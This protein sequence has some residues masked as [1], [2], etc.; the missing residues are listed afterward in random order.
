M[1]LSIKK[2]PHLLA[3]H[4]AAIAAITLF[5]AGACS[6]DGPGSL[7]SVSHSNGGPQLFVV[8]TS[9]IVGDW[10]SRV[11]GSRVEVF[12][13]LPAGADPHSF[14]PGARDVTKVAEADIVFSVGLAL[15]G[16]W[17][18]KMVR[19]AA[20]DESRV[21]AL[22]EVVGPVES[23]PHFWFDP[24][25]AKAAVSHIAAR[26][27]G[28]DPDGA[29]AYDSNSREYSKE[30]DELHDWIG[31]QITSIPPERRLLVTSHDSF[32]YLA[33]R[34]GFK[35]IGTVAPGV[36]TEVEPS[37]VEMVRL[38]ED[39]RRQGVKAIFTEINGVDRLARA[40][41]EETGA[42]LVN[43]LYTGSLGDGSG[44]A[45]TYIRMMRT[46]VREIVGALRQ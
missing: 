11:G 27:S 40:I 2:I 3:R 23:D 32:G 39:V 43:G 24:L 13:L 25:R 4:A 37:A 45:G 22:G 20:A 12:S 41:A 28:L 10:V 34:Y 35:V 42:Q 19:N 17:L 21:V 6:N 30:L 29:E 38:I 44:G 26:L 7:G 46:N 16:A 14:Q 5:L 18:D 33:R 15:E 9:N 36:T 8:T 1:R 31:G